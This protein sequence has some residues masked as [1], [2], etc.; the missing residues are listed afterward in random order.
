MINPPMIIPSMLPMGPACER[1]VLAV[2]TSDPQPMLVPNENARAAE[3]EKDDPNLCSGFF[4]I[5]LTPNSNYSNFNNS[6][7]P[8]L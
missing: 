3:M 2:T 7:L 5:N 6:D 4:C 1:Y 8:Q